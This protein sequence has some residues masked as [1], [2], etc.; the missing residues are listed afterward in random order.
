MEPIIYKLSEFGPEKRLGY[1][2]DNWLGSSES[3][4]FFTNA[5]QDSGAWLRPKIPQ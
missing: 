2:M 4:E 1:H 5:Y 3:V